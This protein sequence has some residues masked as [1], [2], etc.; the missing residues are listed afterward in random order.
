MVHR[1]EMMLAG[2]PLII[3][4]GKLAGQ[5]NGAVTVQYGETIVLATATASQMS[6]WTKRYRGALAMG[7]RLAR[8]PA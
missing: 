3:E 6:A 2:R 8:L 5:A 1:Y 4:T 7:S